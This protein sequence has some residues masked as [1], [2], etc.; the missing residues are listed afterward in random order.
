MKALFGKLE[1]LLTRRP[2]PALPDASLGTKL[3]A[4]LD[5]KDLSK[6]QRG[7]SIT[8]LDYAELP[9]PKGL[10]LSF[11]GQLQYSGCLE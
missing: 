7:C 11:Q 4:D 3:K 1:L 8:H 10:S 2:A 9:K 5:F 6:A